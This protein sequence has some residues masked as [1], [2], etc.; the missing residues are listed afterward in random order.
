MFMTRRTIGII[1][2][3][4]GV[5]LAPI[6]HGVSGQASL[7]SGL[8]GFQAWLDMARRHVPGRLDGAILEQ[9][10]IPLERHF[11]LGVD[12]EA[13]IQFA[14]NPNLQQLGRAGRPYSKPEQALLKRLAAIERAA[15]TTDQLLRQI[16]LLE[17]DG[18]MLA[19][20]QKFIVAPTSSR[21]PK[22]MILSRDGIGLQVVV[23]P[24]NWKIARIALDAV[25]ADPQARRWIRLWY[26]ATTAYLFWDHVLSVI[27]EHVAGWQRVLPD[28]GEAWFHEGCAY[29]VFGGSRIQHARAD[30]RRKGHEVKV[31]DADWNLG[32][33]RRQ[34]EQ[35]L[36]RNPDHVEARLRLA[37]VKSIQGDAP[38]AVKDLIALL[39]DLGTDREL[40]YLAQ[41]FLG[42]AYEATGDDAGAR[43]AYTEAWNHYPLALSP[44][45]SRLG[46]D[47][48]SDGAADALA[49]LLRQERIRADDPWLSYHLGPG[50]FGPNLA[51]ALWA[52]SRAQ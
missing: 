50:R 6:E 2:L 39:P 37:R 5:M 36:K 41:L 34:F 3:I 27:P 9:R 29:E 32:Q 49:T 48:P 20:G 1:I 28:D 43:T 45:I 13:L 31:E 52:A 16:A 25:S 22:D 23:T 17:S 40:L 4:A 33:A 11:A 46:L 10:G 21:I 26:S 15:G 7:A 18:V 14:R 30:S 12:L 42:A 47:P 51:T 35:A 44:R 19:G 38:A 8:D 24:P